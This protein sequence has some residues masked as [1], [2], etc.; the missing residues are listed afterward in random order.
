MPQ[1]TSLPIKLASIFDRADG[2]SPTLGGIAE[3]L[4]SIKINDAY[5]TIGANGETIFF[6]ELSDSPQIESAE[7]STIVHRFHC[8]YLTA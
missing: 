1:L 8:D 7:Q 5:N 4:E 2:S 3:P 6:Y